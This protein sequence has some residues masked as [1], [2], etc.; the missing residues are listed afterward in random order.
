MMA[1]FGCSGHLT[2]LEY[3]I[4]VEWFEFL[5]TTQNLGVDLM[6]EWAFIRNSYVAKISFALKSGHCAFIRKLLSHR[7]LLLKTC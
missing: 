3:Q 4:L 7:S 2:G 5:T 1:L 6:G